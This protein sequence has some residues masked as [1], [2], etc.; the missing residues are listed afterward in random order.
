MDDFL[1]SV[2]MSMDDIEL[3]PLYIDIEFSL[4]KIDASN[5]PLE[6][7]HAAEAI[8]WGE[9]YAHCLLLQEKRFTLRVETWCLRAGLHTRGCAALYESLINID[10]FL[11]GPFSAAESE[12]QAVAG[13]TDSCDSGDEL[14]AI[15][16][17]LSTQQ[18]L[19][20]CRGSMLGPDHPVTLEQLRAAGDSYD[21]AQ[22]LNFSQIVSALS[23]ANIWYQSVSLPSLSEQFS[24]AR[25]LLQR[26]E[27]TVNTDGDGYQLDCTS[28]F[29]WIND[30]CT[31][32]SSFH[33]GERHAERLLPEEKNAIASFENGKKIKSRQ[34]VTLA[35][36]EVL[37]YF[38][39]VEPSHPAPI[40][41]RRAQKM[42]GMDFVT[43][44]EDMLPDALATLQTFTGK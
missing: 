5:D 24:S 9:I 25:E 31:Y 38:E 8:N 44:V 37:A 30:F 16:S 20:L 35:L 14:A 13:A 21:E 43:I 12:R 15:L 2:S 23:Q 39:K 28:L 29:Q 3:D 32:I 26:I 11:S 27:R 34:D 17:W 40:L 42:I 36:D 7:I 33:E 22:G 41:I 18:C 19:C 4:A 1:S 6:S 10:R